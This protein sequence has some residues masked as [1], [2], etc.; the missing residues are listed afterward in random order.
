MRRTLGNGD[1]ITYS[2]DA[3]G[4]LLRLSNYTSAGGTI[5]EYDYTYDAAGRVVGMNSPSGAWTYVHDA[6][7]QITS[8]T[9]PGGTVQY[10]YDAAGNRLSSTNG[11]T[12]VYLANNLNEY[13]SAGSAAYTYDADGNLISG[14]G[15]TY[16]YDDENR[17]VAESSA[18]DTW[19]YQYDG[20]GNRLSA[21]HNGTLTQYL[22]DLSGFGNVEAEFDSTGHLISH[23]A[24]GLDL[25]GAFPAAGTPVYYHFDGSGNTT[26]LTTSSGAVVNSYSY[27]PFGEKLSATGTATNP[28]TYAGE[29]GVMDEGSGL[30]FMRNR[31]YNPSLGRFQQI[32]PIG[33][34]GD[35]NLYRYAGNDPLT[36]VDPSGNDA[37]D[38]LWNSAKTFSGSAGG[39]ATKI[40]GEGLLTAKDSYDL[41]NSINDHDTL[42]IIHDT[43][44]VASRPLSFL[45]PE[46]PQAPL[47]VVAKSAGKID[48][49]SKIAFNGGA[50]L[51]YYPWSAPVHNP[52]QPRPDALSYLIPNFGCPGC[53]FPEIPI[54]DINIPIAKSKDPNGKLTSG[55]G[56][57]G[58]MPPNVAIPYTIYFENQSTATAP[59]QKVTVTDQ[60]TAN[61]DWST[62]QLN[63]IEFNNVTVN[64]PAGLQNYST[65]VNVSTDP[66]PVNVTVAFNSNTGVLTSTMQSVSPT[67]GGAPANPLAGFLPPNNASNQGTGFVT[68][69]V[70]PKSTLGN[71]AA[72]ANQA[73]I[74]FDANAA[75]ATN[76]V[77]N[78]I[79]STTPTS[80][81][82]PLPA[83]STTQSFSVSWTGSDPG[84]SGIAVYNIFVSIDGGAYATWM[85]NTT[86]TA[87][88]YT[89][90]AGHQYSFYSMAVNNVGTIQTN[91]GTAQ[92]AMI[93]ASAAPGVCDVN[94]YGAVTISDIQS[95][96]NQALGAASPVSDLN[97]DGVVNVI[98]AQIVMNAML[99]LGCTL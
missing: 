22:T 55:F 53:L 17:L 61:L 4:K 32:D 99:G 79:D 74:V 6:S 88:A 40:M 35:V 47:V 73:S 92:A 78:T 28:F 13:V 9:M 81:V 85:A 67:T 89:G 98:D 50:A 1:Y 20:L 94:N 31:W 90:F 66:N 57:Q 49:V 54:P 23:Y 8:V 65:Q 16:T 97:H 21:T 71:G 84:G 33:I 36:F 69:S 83:T 76:T 39:E 34:L 45:P 30:Y 87:A 72:I 82:S 68:I 63:Q 7:G 18:T 56:T 25:A 29:F 5:G 12:A 41:A 52:T 93:A 96:I 60:L 27:L 14:G 70:S 19:T 11:G 91:P 59:A 26:Q 95:V 10:T 43:A 38:T 80:A 46:G 48:T 24:Y 42:G 75:I 64:V 2:Y 77:T 15:R 86:A 62:L 58:F 37:L 3:A 44:L 51:W